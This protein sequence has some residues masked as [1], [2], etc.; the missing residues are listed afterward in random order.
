MKR[1]N[2]SLINDKLAEQRQPSEEVD[3]IVERP[4]SLPEMNRL[5]QHSNVTRLQQQ[6]AVQRFG[7]HYGNQQVLRLLDSLKKASNYPVAREPAPATPATPPTTATVPD[8]DKKQLM[9]IQRQLQ[10]LGLYIMGVDGIFG[11]G[12]DS[13]LVEAFGDDNWRTLDPDV[14]LTRLKTAKLPAGKRG[15]HNFRYGEMFKDGLLDMTLGVGFD[16]G[17]DHKS[18]IENFQKVLGTR[19]FELNKEL[20]VKLLAKAGHTIG[21]DSFSF[22]FVKENALEYKPPAQDRSEKPRKINAVVRLVANQDGSQGA[23]A[24]KA[25]REGMT[26]SDIAYYSGH[27]RYGSGPDFDRNFSL[28]ELLNQAGEVEQSTN[29]YEALDRILRNEGR[30]HGRTAWQ[31]FEWR[32]RHKRIRVQSSNDGNVYLNPTDKH[33]EEF[34]AKLIYW[35]LN[36]SAAEGGKAPITGKKGALAQ[37]SKDHPERRYHLIVFDGCRTQDYETSL[38]HTPGH[39]AHSTDILA[40]K[41]TVDWG[42]EVGTLAAFLDSVLEMQSAE[43]TIKGMDEQQGVVSSGHSIPEAYTGLGLNDNPII[44]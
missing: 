18:T 33:S 37:D 7:Q 2:K 39:D 1:K 12:T 13:A 11:R 43:Q 30:P 26:Q 36:R 32:D 15:Q 19:D 42:D 25:F 10:R 16:E 28:F 40:T 34:G 6:Q 8:W 17:G 3:E 35:S 9:K 29:D 21:E 14:I 5:L 23:A 41:R 20:A 24:A 27:G 44:K 4:L 22:F 31:Q 38:R